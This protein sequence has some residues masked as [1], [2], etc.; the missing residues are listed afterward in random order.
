VQTSP[1]QVLLA[2]QSRFSRH[3]SPSAQGAQIPPPQS[4]AVS[5]PSGRLSPQVEAHFPDELQV[6]AGPQSLGALHEPPSAHAGQ[7]PPQSTSVSVPFLTWSPQLAAAQ[8]LCVQTPDAQSLATTQVCAVVHLGQVPPPQSWSV[9]LPLMTLS[10]QVAARHL[11]LLQVTPDGQ[12]HAVVPAFPR[13]QTPLWQSSFPPHP[14]PAGQ[15]K[16]TPPSILLTLK[17]PM[18]SEVSTIPCVPELPFVSCT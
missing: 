11:F 14:S 2:P 12:G 3:A 10:V 15:S 7:P 18:V 4:V 6:L 9:S 5:L 1:V 17:F 13:Q 16:P 8:A